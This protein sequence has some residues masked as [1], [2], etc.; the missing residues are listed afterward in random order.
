[1]SDMYQF[2]MKFFTAV[3]LTPL[4]QTHLVYTQSLQGMKIA[5][6]AL[7]GRKKEGMEALRTVDV[8]GAIMTPPCKVCLRMALELYPTAIKE[9]G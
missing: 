2:D 8:L 1:M 5:P 9:I 3:L 4:G 6:R 7:C